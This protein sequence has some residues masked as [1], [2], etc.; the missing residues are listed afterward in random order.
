MWET[1]ISLIWDPSQG[2]SVKPPITIL[3]CLVNSAARHSPSKPRHCPSTA[4]GIFSSPWNDL[5]FLP[6][7]GNLRTK[8]PSKF[9]AFPSL[10]PG[11]MPISARKC[12]QSSECHNFLSQAPKNFKFWKQSQKLIFYNPLKFEIIFIFCQNVM[13]FLVYN[14]WKLFRM[15]YLLI[16]Y[17]EWLEMFTTTRK[18]KNKASLKISCVSQHLSRSYTHFSSKM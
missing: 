1:P 2:L 17:S 16:I 12:R 11:V 14:S 8:H 10:C 13:A 9:H 3:L 6:Q 5:K 7:L 4:Q 15:I 18:P